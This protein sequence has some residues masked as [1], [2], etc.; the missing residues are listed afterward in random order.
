MTRK[1]DTTD[2]RTDSTSSGEQFTARERN[3]I[4]RLDVS[5]HIGTRVVTLVLAAT[6]AFLLV[7]IVLTVVA[8]FATSWT[9]VLPRG[10]VT[11]DNWLTVL[12]LADGAGVRQGVIGGLVFSA[13]LATAGMAIN[14][15][16]GVPIAYALVRY[17]FYAKDWINTLAI[18]PIVPGI[19]LAVAFLR[20]YPEYGGSAFGLIVGYALL[21]SPYMVLTVQSSFQSMNLQRIEESARSLGASWPRTFSTVVV[22]NAKDGIVAGSI[23]TWT[24]AAAEFNFTYMVHARGPQPFS[25]FLFENITRSPVLQGAAAVSVYFL[26]VSAVIVLLQ[27]LGKAGFTTVER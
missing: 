27:V 23:I 22:P 25:L 17:D 3:W 5:S 8:S 12:G 19:V 20:T 16:V 24:L 15:V 18:L 13:G 6:L 2:R 1:T 10:F 14:V 26:I 21:K 11:V 9:G 4:R 7:P